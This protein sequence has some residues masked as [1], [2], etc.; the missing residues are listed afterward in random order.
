SD[1][2]LSATIMITTTAMLVAFPVLAQAGSLIAPDDYEIIG[3]RP[4]T[5]RTYF[6]VRATAL[7]LQTAEMA[8]FTGYLPVVAFLTRSHG[9]ARQAFA[10]AAAV[11]C[12]AATTTLGLAAVY[13][14]FLKMLPP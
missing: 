1:A 9:S 3:Y 8:L 12:A 7:V 6:A 5:S 10:A 11:A 13:G 2:W 14:W 4:V